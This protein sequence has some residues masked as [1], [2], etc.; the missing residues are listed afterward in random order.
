[1]LLQNLVEPYYLVTNESSH[2]R[3]ERG[4]LRFS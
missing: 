2:N 3:V 4:T 1:M